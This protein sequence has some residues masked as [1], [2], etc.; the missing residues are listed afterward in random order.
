M[1]S[2]TEQ[3]PHIVI[4]GASGFVG[5]ALA[6]HILKSGYPTTILTRKIIDLETEVET[7]NY[8]VVDYEDVHTLVLGIPK[9]SIIVNLIY[10]GE[11]LEKNINIVKN[12]AYAAKKCSARKF[13]HIS[14][15]VTVGGVSVTKITEEVKPKPK[16]EYEK[17]KHRM[18]DELREEF[19]NSATQLF[20]LK[21]T[22]IFGP[23]GNNLWKLYAE[24][25]S[26][27]SFFLYLKACVNKNRK[28]HLVRLE[29][30]L[31]SILFAIKLQS[32]DGYEEFLISDDDEKLNEFGELDKFI[33]SRF[34]SRRKMMPVVGFPEFIVS[35]ALSLR[36]LSDVDSR[37]VYCDQRLRDFGFN[38]DSQSFQEALEDTLREFDA[39][40]S[41]NIGTKGGIDV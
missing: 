23:R 5:R 36:G 16:T 34:D 28:A 20:I 3:L 40:Y 19:K 2:A 18:D 41:E 24:I 4:L 33:R 6:S 21:P 13:I 12:I 35:L 30:V 1:L 25:R 22:E 39:R 32:V 8:K 14:T 9:K 15:A 37:R 27:G 26:E 10:A 7:L 17:I 11:N 31:N 38:D 29:K